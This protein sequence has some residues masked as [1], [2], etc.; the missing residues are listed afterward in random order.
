M[1]LKSLPTGFAS[2]AGGCETGSDLAL[3]HA[4]PFAAKKLVFVGPPGKQA[5]LFDQ[6]MT[7]ILNKEISHGDRILAAQFCCDN[8]EPRG[9]ELAA[10]AR[11]FKR[12]IQDR[13]DRI[14]RER[15][16]SEADGG[17]Q[18]TGDPMEID[19]AGAQEDEFW[20]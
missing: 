11:R 2:P 10:M 4:G 9:E 8:H 18:G 1:S 7:T 14:Y 12:D 13:A 3:C 19:V 15:W 17:L 20:D 5:R 16:E 6:L